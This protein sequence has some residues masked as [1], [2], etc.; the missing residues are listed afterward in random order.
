MG[1]NAALDVAIAL[2][3]MY[4]LISIM[5]TVVN[6]I[7]ATAMKLRASTLRS[8]L[9]NIIDHPSLRQDFYNHGLIA[10]T[11]DA[12]KGQ[13]VSYLSGQTFALAILGSLDPTKPIPGF[14][15]AKSAIE[16]MPDTNI[17][18]ALLAQLTLA[19]NDLQKL[20]DGIAGWFDSAMD[21]VGGAYKRNMKWISLA[22]GLAITLILGA[23]TIQMGRA[24]WVDSTLR[25]QI[26][27]AAAGV[28][29]SYDPKAASNKPLFDKLKG[30]DDNIRALPIGWQNLPDQL[31]WSSGVTW[32]V[33][34][35]GLILTALAVSLGAPFWF[36]LLSKFMNVRGTGQ[37][38]PR[39]NQT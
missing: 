28:Q 32:L 2:V 5:V 38:P 20:R 9:E 17:R 3:L 22:V 18:D 11:E 4:L 37:R 1:N 34:F 36:D 10:G 25:A 14:A 39:S 31:T 12:L 7:L 16:T 23:D 33:K 35:I 30:D 26:V 24:I 6:E 15:D 8:A 19:D 13:H 21:R 29:A 27:Q